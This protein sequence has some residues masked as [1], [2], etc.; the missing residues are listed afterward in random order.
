MFC[1]ANGLNLA[2]SS[3]IELKAVSPPSPSAFELLQQL[4][5]LVARYAERVRPWRLEAFLLW[6]LGQP[7]AAASSLA[8]REQP[9]AAPATPARDVASAAPRGVGTSAP[10]ERVAAFPAVPGYGEMS[11]E[12]EAARLIG[13]LLRRMRQA[14]KASMA[15]DPIANLDDF[16]LM[17]HVLEQPGIHKTELIARNH[18]ELSSGSDSIARLIRAGLLVESVDPNDRRARKLKVS[19]SG[20]AA[21][22]RSFAHMNAVAV[23][24]FAPL[25]SEEVQQLSLVLSK[26]E[27]A[28][29]AGEARG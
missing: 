21:L 8:P 9:L 22:Q 11:A 16:G 20:F 15:Q 3:A 25:S 17:V 7:E 18:M 5:A 19:P 2:V 26:V 23:A 1:F 28:L 10:A 13:T 6:A 29:S 4:T 12:G 24:T 14:A 27:R